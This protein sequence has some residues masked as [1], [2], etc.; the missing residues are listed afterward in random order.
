MTRYDL[1]PMVYLSYDRIAMKGIDDPNLRITF[2]SNIRWRA[3]QLD[4]S[5]GD[6]GSLKVADN[7]YIMEIKTCGGMPIW[8]SDALNSLRIYPKSY[9]KYGTIYKEDLAKNLI[10]ENTGGINCA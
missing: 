4:L 1:C 8:L 3:E 6:F 5:K 9:S 7:Q 10:Q 2:D